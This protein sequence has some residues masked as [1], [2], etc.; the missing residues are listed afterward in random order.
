VDLYR[1]LALELGVRP[2]HR[3]SQVWADLKKALL[4]LV[5]ER[6]THPIV[7]I[8]EA[9]HLSDAFLM[10]LSGFLNFAFDSHFRKMLFGPILNTPTWTLP[11]F[12]TTSLR[13]IPSFSIQRRRA[14]T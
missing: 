9:Q 3:R 4:H 13:V 14:M 2:S 7:V 11:T 1:A 5:D 6:G 10:D 12:T 8:D